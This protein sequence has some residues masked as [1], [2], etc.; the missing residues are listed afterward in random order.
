MDADIW[1]ID[2]FDNTAETVTDLQG[3]G[4]RVICYCLNPRM[5][6]DVV[7]EILI[8]CTG[9]FFLG[10]MKSCDMLFILE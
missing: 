9:W 10:T 3:K 6:L 7:K 2:L 5:T 8:L 1:D 4:K